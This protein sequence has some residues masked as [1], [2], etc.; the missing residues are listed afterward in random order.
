MK[1]Q[2]VI[3]LLPYRSEVRGIYISGAPAELA[4]ESSVRRL[5]K[6]LYENKETD[7]IY[8]IQRLLDS[9]H[10]EDLQESYRET[11]NVLGLLHKHYLEPNNTEAKYIVKSIASLSVTGTGKLLGV[12]DSLLN[13]CESLPRNPPLAFA[14]NLCLGNRLGPIVFTC[15]EI[16]RFSTAG[17]LGVMVDELSQGLSSLGQEV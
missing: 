7:G 8:L 16:G 4:L 3:A 11:A 2:H 1:D 13:K 5:S 15:P 6:K 9:L 12:C 17:G 10:R 14:E